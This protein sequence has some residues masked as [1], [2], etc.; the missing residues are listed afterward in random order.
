MNT[1][2]IKSNIRAQKYRQI[3]KFKQNLH[4]K[5]EMHDTYEKASF[6]GATSKG[7]NHKYF[8]GCC[9]SGQNVTIRGWCL[10]ACHASF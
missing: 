7:I 1:N 8:Q 10:L 9:V 3:K 6:N 4:E 2:K 5:E